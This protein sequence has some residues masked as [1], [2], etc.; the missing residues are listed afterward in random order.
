MT[1]RQFSTP[2]THSVRESVATI[3]TPQ[4]TLADICADLLRR[5]QVSTPPKRRN[6]VSKILSQ[7]LSGGELV[8]AGKGHTED[9]RL[10]TVYERAR[11]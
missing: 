5:Y 11:T 9:G 10:V 3:A 4:F 7:M 8:D 6:F 2:L 1:S